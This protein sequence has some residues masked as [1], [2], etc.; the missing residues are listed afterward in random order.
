M[1]PIVFQYEDCLWFLQFMLVINLWLILII[2]IQLILPLHQFSLNS[3]TFY[4][5]FAQD[6]HL[7]SNDNLLVYQT[8]EWCAVY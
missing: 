6:T 7:H 4:C 2:I 1:V 5:H 8:F 3:I